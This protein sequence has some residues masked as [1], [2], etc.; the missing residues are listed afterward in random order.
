MTKYTT[1]KQNNVMLFLMYLI[2]SFTAMGIA[3]F[4]WVSTEK[5]LTTFDARA[6]LDVIKYIPTGTFDILLKVT[7]YVLLL[8]LTYLFRSYRTSISQPIKLLTLVADLCIAFRVV[9]LLDFNYN[10]ILL[11]VFAN[12]LIYAGKGRYTMPVIGAGM[13]CYVLTN[14]QL[15]SINS[16]IYDI[17]DYI[18]L[19]NSNM[20]PYLFGVYNGMA[21]LSIVCFIGCCLLIIISK[22]E[23]LEETNEL[24]TKLAAANEN[25]QRANEEL[26]SIMEEN[27]KMAEVKE[28]N[29]IAREIHDTMGHTLTGLA[30][31][32]DACI[33]LSDTSPELV[34]QQLQIL[35]E[36]SRKG[37]SDVRHSVSELRP[38]ALE[39]LN[40]EAAIRQLVEDTVKVTGAKVQFS[41]SA[42]VLKFDEDEESA[43]YR[44]IQESITNAIRHGHASEIDVSISRIDNEL[45][46]KVSDN[47]C[48]C[49]DI[50]LK[51]GFGTR[52]IQERIRML[53]GT[54]DFK[55][56]DGFCVEATIP[57]R[58][59]E[60]Y[61]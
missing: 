27:T 43:I 42:G 55:S 49:S 57:I 3:G 44:V 32:I 30:A 18:R 8:G 58:W 17:S 7:A 47:G 45:H 56:K 39:R 51:E 16:G 15:V 1:E 54:V 35:S 19:Y 61:D 38:D 33:A 28:R 59:G 31:G 20:Q 21:I 9:M 60:E 41:C 34:K 50:K 53:N 48:G 5:L 14:Y 36:V 25:L 37:I 13:L 22:E 29:R 6:F 12:V 10:G 52:H 23:L 4:V 26:E 46:L 2:C 11:W 40:L 24:Y